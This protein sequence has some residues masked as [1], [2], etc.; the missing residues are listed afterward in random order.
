MPPQHLLALHKV[1]TMHAWMP[2]FICILTFSLSVVVPIEGHIGM[3][4]LNER[5]QGKNLFHG[6]TDIALHG[7]S[8]SDV[9]NQWLSPPVRFYSNTGSYGQFIDGGDV[10]VT[11]SF[12]WIA[13]VYREETGDGPLMEW[14]Q[15]GSRRTHIWIFS[16]KF[17]I[18]FMR[19]GCNAE[20][21]SFSST[22][23]NQQWYTMALSYNADAEVVS[24]WVDGQLKQAELATCPGKLV[25][26]DTAYIN[27]R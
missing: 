22:M 20:R 17:D 2:F 24:M 10:A 26:P 7:V 9:T 23:N 21:V 27:L 25:T 6:K 15:S 1:L 12:G 3:W 5:F 4:P 13:S 18:Y 11:G 16:N 8:Y 14:Q 19:E